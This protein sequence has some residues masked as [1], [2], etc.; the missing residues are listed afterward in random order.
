MQLGHLHLTSQMCI[1]CVHKYLSDS[2]AQEG[3]VCTWGEGQ[4]RGLA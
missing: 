3:S 4:G 2:L 1:S